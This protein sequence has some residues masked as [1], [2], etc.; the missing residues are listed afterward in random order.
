MNKGLEIDHRNGDKSDNRFE[1][2]RLTTKKQN[3]ENIINRTSKRRN[4]TKDEVRQL[5]QEFIEVNPSPKIKWYRKKAEELS[6]KAW[7][8]I[9]YN[10]LN[11]SNREVV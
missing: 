6:V 2:L 10:I 4:L 9:Q 11:Y 3:H 8:T 7:Q 1:N 5:R